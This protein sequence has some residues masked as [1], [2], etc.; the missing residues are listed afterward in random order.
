MAQPTK[1]QLTRNIQLMYILNMC[2]G[3][4]FWYGIEK[5]FIT[6]KLGFAPRDIAY[7]VMMYAAVQVLF[8][9]PSGALA[10]RWSRRRTMS[11]ALG[12]FLLANIILG[13][14]TN[15]SQYLAGT[16]VWGFYLV[17]FTG[18]E[19]AMLYDSLAALKRESE[20]KKIYGRSQ[21]FFMSGIF[22]SSTA[23]GFIA[24]ATS[25]QTPYFLTLIPIAIGLLITFILVEPPKHKQLQSKRALTH[26]W[27]ATKLLI[28]TKV[29][30]H[31]LLICLVLF[32]V[33]T[34]YY[35]YAQLYYLALF[36]GSTILTG[37]ANGLGGLYIALGNL[38]TKHL[39]FNGFGFALIGAFL[40]AAMSLP[41]S[42]LKYGAFAFFAVCF[43]ATLANVNDLKHR[44]IPTHLRATASSAIS[45]ID[46]LIIV[47]I[48][49][50]FSVIAE[51]R[52]IFAAYRWVAGLALL[53]FL[54]YLTHSKVL[55]NPQQASGDLV[56][57][58]DKI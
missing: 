12:C 21:A 8:N 31:V 43:G 35:E 24:N 15:L 11:L 49:Y 32:L 40:F 42:A 10:D 56:T 17:C 34:T 36:G 48:S 58:V 23:S 20:Y 45:M 1:A 28:A 51:H 30:R 29:L 37:I 14:S 16:L 3:L 38:L 50:G 13:S 6:T 47:P 54:Y 2:V 53:Y 33:Q 19:E 25:L 7:M 4:V 9:I 55:I 26:M 52:S 22:L 46:Y 57:E 39:R 18:T 27:E 5:V 41:S 44:N